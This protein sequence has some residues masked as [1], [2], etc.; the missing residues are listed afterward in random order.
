[1]SE[2]GDIVRQQVA[3]EFTGAGTVQIHDGHVG[4]IKHARILAHIVVLIKLR[5][6]MQRHHPAMKI[7]HARTARQVLIVQW[8]LLCHLFPLSTQKAEDRVLLRNKAVW[9]VEHLTGLI[10]QRTLTAQYTLP[11]W[12]NP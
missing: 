6:V 11:C 7:D 5:T 4:N 12:H 2:L 9:L 1:M 3:Q 10:T 8:G